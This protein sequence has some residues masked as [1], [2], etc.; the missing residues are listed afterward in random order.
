MTATRIHRESKP[1]QRYSPLQPMAKEDRAFWRL[2]SAR[3]EQKG[4]R[5]G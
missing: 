1:T 4:Q 2:L 5:H 3:R